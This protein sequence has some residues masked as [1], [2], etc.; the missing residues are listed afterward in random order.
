MCVGVGGGVFV[1]VCV[2][3]YALHII[4]MHSMGTQFA[5]RNFTD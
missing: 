4:V 3:V 1:C 2:C 5:I